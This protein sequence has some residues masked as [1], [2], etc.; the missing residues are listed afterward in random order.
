LDYEREILPIKYQIC[1]PTC[2]DDLLV[3]TS[4]L[5]LLYPRQRSSKLEDISSLGCGGGGFQKIHPGP[6]LL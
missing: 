5:F 6:P 4:I 1:T 3:L 2:V